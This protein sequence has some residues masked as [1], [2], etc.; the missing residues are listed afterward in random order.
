LSG[1]IGE[2]KMIPPKMLKQQNMPPLTLIG[3]VFALRGLPAR[4]RFESDDREFL[5]NEMFR[6]HVRNLNI[7]HAIEFP[8]AR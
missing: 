3:L 8:L 7:A 5:V 4:N 6:G 2:P 1:N